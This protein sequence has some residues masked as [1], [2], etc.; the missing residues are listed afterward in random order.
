[1]LTTRGLAFVRECSGGGVGWK[2]PAV[3][4]YLSQLT[5]DQAVSLQG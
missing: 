5:L 2:R 1:M 4:A 3:L